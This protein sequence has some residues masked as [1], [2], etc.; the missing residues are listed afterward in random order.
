MAFSSADLQERIE[1]VP[2]RPVVLLEFREETIQQ[3][4]G[5]VGGS[6]HSWGKA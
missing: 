2:S 1:V 6:I 4:A 3:L 5:W